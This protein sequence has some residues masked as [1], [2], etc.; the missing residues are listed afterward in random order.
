MAEI[1]AGEVQR[2]LQGKLPSHPLNQPVNA[3]LRFACWAHAMAGA[4]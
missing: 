4:E 2:L 1:L 3:R